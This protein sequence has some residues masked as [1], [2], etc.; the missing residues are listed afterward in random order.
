MTIEI[1]ILATG[2]KGNA[3]IISEGEHRL[4]IDPGIH[5][6]ELL[7][8][9]GFN[10]ICDGC[11][12]SHE[13]KDHCRAAVD[14]ARLGTELYATLGTSQ[15]IPA[16]CKIIK[17]EIDFFVKYW[18]ILPFST[19]HDAADPVGFL[20]QPPSGRSKLLY[21][22]D[23]YYIRYIF[24]GVT[25]W[26]VEANYQKQILDTNEEMN[27]VHKERV[28]RSH[29]EIDNLAEFFKHQD[30]KKTKAIYL[31]HLSED[32]SDPIAFVKKIEAV[33]GKPVYL[34]D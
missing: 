6:K 9:S 32:N 33:T 24:S 14:V 31:I 10:L 22:S 13:H 20:I 19:Q 2:S 12:I 7:K 1:E 25:H 26:M 15:N 4:M 29:F 23:T 18:H 8:R 16:P 27:P 3:Y 28:R 30:L 17:P 11:L 34:M 21:A 5:I